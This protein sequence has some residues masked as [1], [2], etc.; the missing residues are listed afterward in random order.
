MR[1]TASRQ[2]DPLGRAV[3]AHSLV[4]EDRIVVD[5]EAEQGKRQPAGDLAE[6]VD[7]QR[8]LGTSSGASSVQPDAISVTTSVCA[9]VPRHRTGMR[10]EIG[11]DKSRR[12]IVPVRERPNRYRSADR[13]YRARLP[14]QHAAAFS[15]RLQGP[16][17]G[18][19]AHLQQRRAHFGRGCQMP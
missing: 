4:H 17:D 11:F 1:S 10:D 12:W 6:Y 5:V 2:L 9:N 14:A 3:V 13:R 19:R 18:R 7:Q 8:L 15:L 16:I